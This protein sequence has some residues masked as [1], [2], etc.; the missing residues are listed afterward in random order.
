[1]A[2]QTTGVLSTR[3]NRRKGSNAALTGRDC[4]DTANN[5]SDLDDV[6]WEKVL[7]L[8][9]AIACGR[10]RISAEALAGKLIEH[11]LAAPRLLSA[12][13]D[14]TKDHP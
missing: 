13:F 10:Y 8:R 11:M 1:M 7:S 14:G 2:M 9:A 12:R 6:R 5:V 3:M 4:A